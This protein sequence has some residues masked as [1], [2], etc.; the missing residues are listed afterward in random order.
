MTLAFYIA[1]FKPIS[2]KLINSIIIRIDFWPF[3]EQLL[4]QITINKF[5]IAP[6]TI[7]QLQI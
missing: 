6:S 4:N 1:P 2:N 7:K 3:I 5:Y